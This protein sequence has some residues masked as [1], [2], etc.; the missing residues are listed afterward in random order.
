MFA[1]RRTVASRLRP[2]NSAATI[3]IVCAHSP[4]YLRAK[5]QFEISIANPV[6]FT[7]GFNYLFI[8]LFIEWYATGNTD[9]V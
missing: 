5:K 9:Y 4:F 8:S 6:N 7:N 2:F 3:V 1:V